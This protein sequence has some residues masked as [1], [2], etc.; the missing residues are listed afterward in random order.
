MISSTGLT[1]PWN[2]QEAQLSLS[3]HTSAARYPGMNRYYAV[4][5]QAP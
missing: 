5:Q 3:D 4:A 1:L 2:N